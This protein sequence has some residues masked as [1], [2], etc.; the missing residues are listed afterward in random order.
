MRC[1][2][3]RGRPVGPL[4]VLLGMLAFGAVGAAL[5]PSRGPEDGEGPFV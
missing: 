1:W 3:C 2:W 4:V 5:R